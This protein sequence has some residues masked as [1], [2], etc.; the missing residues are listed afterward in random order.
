[1]DDQRI[2]ELWQVIKSAIRSSALPTADTNDEKMKNI[3]RSLL[4]GEAVCW[5]DNSGGTLSTI[6][7]T[8]ITIE[9]ISE[10]KNLLIYCAH[11][12]RK[13]SAKEY[14]EMV[15]AIGDYA[16][17]HKCDNIIAYVW[18]QKIVELFKKYGAD[19]KYTLI[20][21]PLLKNLT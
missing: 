15:E 19:A 16:R 14:V 6:I 9:N 10:T 20:V 1:M 12:F 7:I 13:Q 8:T 5:Y 3:L 18:N 4:S 11:A 17:A 21:H 2:A